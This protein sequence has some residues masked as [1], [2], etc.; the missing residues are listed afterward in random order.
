MDER[1]IKQE[2]EGHHRSQREVCTEHHISTNNHSHAL[3]IHLMLAYLVRDAACNLI[4]WTLK[5]AQTFVWRQ[6]FQVR[7]F[8]VGASLTVNAPVTFSV[9]QRPTLQVMTRIAVRVLL[10]SVRTSGSAARNSTL[11]P[12][13]V[14]RAK[15]LHLYSTVGDR[16]QVSG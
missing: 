8:L 5:L 4:R 6:V 1:A 13:G 2:E 10:V 9:S 14:I 15:G 16:S 11:I 7:R 12:G 3:A